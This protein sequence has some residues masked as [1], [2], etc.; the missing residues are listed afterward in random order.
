MDT[1]IGYEQDKKS[2]QRWRVTKDKSGITISAEAISEEEYNRTLAKKTP[3]AETKAEAEA[4]A[5][6]EKRNGTP[7]VKQDLPPAAEASPAD[8]AITL[9]QDQLMGNEGIGDRMGNT[10]AGE[11]GVSLVRKAEIE[12]KLGVPLSDKD[13]R[14]EVVREDSAALHKRLAGFDTLGPTVQAAILDLAYNIGT[15][16][17]LDASE[18]PKLQRAVAEGNV[19]AILVN[20]LDTATVNGKSVKGIA[21]R[22]ARLFNQANDNS[23]LEITTV[24]QLTD[25]TINYLAGS[26]VIH[27][28]IRPRHPDS[29]AGTMNIEKIVVK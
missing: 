26:R 23:E 19:E 11:G 27:T 1:N 22:R 9:V 14:D 8:Q 17:I 24:E 3:E 16:K 15:N 18:F 20:T 10:P 4:E 25:G 28:F 6:A 13:A 21:A 2:G 7:V 12:A 5:K 29:A